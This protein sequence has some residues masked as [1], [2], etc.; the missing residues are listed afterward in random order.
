MMGNVLAGMA[1]P[2]KT[3]DLMEQQSIIVLSYFIFHL[4]RKKERDVG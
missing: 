1:L 3:G 4:K 2:E